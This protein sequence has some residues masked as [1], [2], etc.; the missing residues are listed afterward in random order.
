MNGKLQNWQAAYQQVLFEHDYQRLSN[1]VETAETA[2]FVR[3]QGLLDGASDGMSNTQ[4][5][6]ERAEINRA[7]ETLRVIKKDRLKFPD[8]RLEQGSRPDHVLC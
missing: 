7:L 8:W 5:A 4:I 1:A 2:I 3:C 6:S